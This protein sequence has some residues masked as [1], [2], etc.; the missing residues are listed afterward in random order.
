MN[1]QLFFWLLII[2]PALAKGQDNNY[3]KAMASQN[4]D[5][6][7]YYIDLHIQSAENNADTATIVDGTCFKVRKL[8]AKSLYTR[9]EKLIDKCLE[10]SYV[11]KNKQYEGKLYLELGSVSKFRGN[12]SKSISCYQKAEKIFQQQAA[13]NDLV[14]C[15]TQIAEYY[16][17]LA[18]YTEANIYINDAL[19]S[20]KSY[21]LS[22]TAILISVYNRA[23]AIAN[24]SNKDLNVTL[25]YSRMALW[26]AK[27]TGNKDAEAT[28]L[29]E[30]GFTYQNQNKVDSAHTL[31]L[32]AEETWF[33]IG[34]NS[35]AVHAMYNRITLKDRNK[36]PID[37]IIR[38]YK[39]LIDIVTRNNIDYPL[40]E[41]YGS[42]S[43]YYLSFGDTG[44]AYKYFYLYHGKTLDEITQ[45]N[46]IEIINVTEQY[47]S[48][49][50]KQEVKRVSNELSDSL[51]TIEAKSSEAKRMYF[52][53]SLLV[54]LLLVIA[55][56]LYRISNANKKLSDRNKEKDVLIQEIHHRVKNN[57]Q[58][59]S[60]LLNMQT[61]SSADDREKD[62]LNDASRRIRAMALV[63]EMLYNHKETTGISIKQYLQEL[64]LSLDQLVNSEK[65]PIDFKLDFQDENFNVSD[66]IALGIITS[67]LVSNSMKHAFG[68]ITKPVIEV[69][70]KKN[71][72]KVVYIM[73]DN[74]SGIKKE[75]EKNKTLGLRLID[76]FS[77]QLKGKYHISSA[78]GYKYELEFITR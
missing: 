11:K 59:I 35:S 22:D 38:M 14:K 39:Y 34:A 36:A 64:V 62:T 41:A 54:F 78:D 18:K 29:N 60:S 46:D 77:R 56:L 24:E 10:Y 48:E 67:E 2:I 44:M 69:A 9:A 37:T 70:L 51:L 3:D 63:H 17:K 49:K 31:Y 8:I 52:F 13:Y 72:N 57:L 21:K 61:N 7:I 15:K 76:I 65:I 19:N 66:S 55:F 58:F 33:S 6:A 74:G 45:R 32:L 27:K 40:R 1:R 5:S 53:I 50:A 42:L 16:R 73:R 47:E 4:I 30:L 75:I 68:G 12:F 20:C 25:K 71:E 26:L 23:A 28:S 43:N